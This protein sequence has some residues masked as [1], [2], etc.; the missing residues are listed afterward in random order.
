[1]V[2]LGIIVRNMIRSF[3][4]QDSESLLARNMR[5]QS[6]FL[7]PSSIARILFFLSLLIW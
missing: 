5:Y 6:C 7:S 3:A 1:L 4:E 2:L